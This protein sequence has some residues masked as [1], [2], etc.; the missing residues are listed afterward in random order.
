[1]QCVSNSQVAVGLVGEAERAE[2]RRRVN[3]GVEAERIQ[4]WGN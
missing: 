2:G 3:A 4:D 1:M